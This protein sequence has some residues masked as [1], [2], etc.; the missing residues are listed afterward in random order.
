MIRQQFHTID[1]ENSLA[2]FQWCKVLIK[3]NNQQ[4]N[5]CV[6]IFHALIKLNAKMFDLPYFNILAWHVSCI[7]LPNVR[8]LL[9]C[10]I[11]VTS[12]TFSL[13]WPWIFLLNNI[14]IGTSSKHGDVVSIE[15]H[16]IFLNKLL[17]I[18]FFVSSFTMISSSRFSNILQ[19]CK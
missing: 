1:R 6:S 15:N 8:K 4:D 10:I 9:F 19:Q 18:D 5:I 3:C 2:N 13:L 7:V 12:N 16:L 17:K 11:P 14:S